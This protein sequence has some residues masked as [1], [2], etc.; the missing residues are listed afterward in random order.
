[1][2]WTKPYSF[3]QQSDSGSLTYSVTAAQGCAGWNVTLQATNF[4]GAGSAQGQTIPATNFAVTGATTPQGGPTVPNS[5]G[6]LNQP[7]KVLSG[8]ENSPAGTYSQTVSLGVTIPGGTRVGIYT[9]TVTVTAAS[10]P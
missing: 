10:G 5:S 8:A 2:S 4:A 3:A 7:V 6:T 1:M 9:S